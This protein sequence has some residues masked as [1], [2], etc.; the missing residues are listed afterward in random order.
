MFKDLSFATLGL[1]GTQAE[2]IELALS[3]G[4]KGIDVDLI[5]FEQRVQ[6]QGLA[7]ARRL[8]DSAKIRLSAFQLP[9][10]ASI[11]DAEF[12]PELVKLKPLA[13]L[14]A[15]VGCTRAITT[16]APASDE[17]PYHANFEFYRKRYNDI[18][19]ALAPHNIRLGVAFSADPALRKER[20]FEFI[21]GLDALAMLIGLVQA[22]NIGVV[23]D[24]WDVWRSGGALDDLRKLQANQIVQVRVADAPAD[25][26]PDDAPADSRLLPGES[27]VIDAS[28]LLVHLV[29]IG[30]D[31]PVTPAP[32]RAHFGSASRESIVKQA[33][34]ALDK[35]WKAA[36]LTP[37]G[38][39]APTAKK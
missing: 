39:L 38:K 9:F 24:L 30:Y 11:D 35:V 15:T 16:L 8:V 12:Q 4:F 19:A 37:A 5:E 17:R 21:H 23:V 34:Q 32:S 22:R 14:A 33:G 27:G 29:E 31:G 2:Q 25:V 7:H 26:A 20:A 6:A 13:E 10:D 18:A 3:Y 1:A 36:G 28:A